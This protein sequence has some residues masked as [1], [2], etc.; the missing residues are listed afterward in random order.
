MSQDAKFASRMTEASEGKRDFFIIY[1]RADQTWAE[2]VG[3]Q[4]EAAGYTVFIQAWDFRPGH[5]FALEMDRAA[6]LAERTVPVLSPRVALH[7]AR[8][9]GSVCRPDG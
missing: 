7:S 6:T 4:L 2:W 1:N 9:G 5:N 8:V 3:W